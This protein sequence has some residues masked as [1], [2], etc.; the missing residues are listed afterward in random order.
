MD[1]MISE[2]AAE[3]DTKAVSHWQ[4]AQNSLQIALL[5]WAWLQCWSGM[6]YHGFQICEGSES[7]KHIMPMVVL[8][9]GLVMTNV[10]GFV[11]FRQ[12]GFWRDACLA[13]LDLDTPYLAYQH[14]RQIMLGKP[15]PDWELLRLR[16]SIWRSLPLAMVGFV[17]AFRIILEIPTCQAVGTLSTFAVGTFPELMPWS[18]FAEDLSKNGVNLTELR[19]FQGIQKAVQKAAQKVPGEYKGDRGVKV[20]AK[21]IHLEHALWAAAECKDSKWRTHDIA[22]FAESQD[23]LM[24]GSELITTHEVGGI[25]SANLVAFDSML[26]QYFKSRLLQ[27]DTKRAVRPVLERM[28][29][30]R[31]TVMVGVS[32]L[33][34]WEKIVEGASGFASN[35]LKDERARMSVTSHRPWTVGSDK[36]HFELRDGWKIRLLQSFTLLLVAILPIRKKILQV[37]KITNSLPM[38]LVT[39]H[40]SLDTVSLVTTWLL[41]AMASAAYFTGRCVERMV[42][43]GL[44]FAIQILVRMEDA[45]AKD[46]HRERPGLFLK[47]AVDHGG[48]ILDLVHET[49]LP[50]LAWNP[51]FFLLRA[52]GTLAFIVI[53]ALLSRLLCPQRFAMCI[54]VGVCGPLWLFTD[55]EEKEDTFEA[56]AQGV[57]LLM[58]AR[59]FFLA[60]IVFFTWILVNSSSIQLFFALI[61]NRVLDVLSLKLYCLA[62]FAANG[63]TGLL[64]TLTIHDLRKNRKD[65]PSTQPAHMFLASSHSSAYGT[66]EA[67]SQ[68]SLSA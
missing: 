60:S 43:L 5:L 4:M 29:A 19:K 37:C 16:N 57:C 46:F 66:F 55:E 34:S 51:Y 25:G 40:T 26:L 22:K 47:Y 53:S 67:R 3:V 9:V 52:A 63:L 42:E 48:Q 18:N 44:P 33:L 62:L 59:N 30:K 11:H 15:C 45:T 58:I 2:D 36:L 24:L 54:S 12:K 32:R 65:G 49:M 28:V 27:E 21:A 35:M 31:S 14:G 1:P 56:T 41:C 13:A 38:A 68:Q 39:L 10:I 50:A 64:A 6:F 20:G 17:L 7:I 23:W 61:C 8:V